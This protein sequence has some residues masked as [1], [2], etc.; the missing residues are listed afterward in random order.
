[1]RQ[2]TDTET[3][4][5]ENRVGD[6][7]VNV[8]VFAAGLSREFSASWDEG[9]GWRDVVSLRGWAGLS[10]VFGSTGLSCPW[11]CGRGQIERQQ[12]ANMYRAAMGMIPATLSGDG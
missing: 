12:H 1:M 2:R 9:N 6:E 7:C 8:C 11:E 3:S 10:C 4:D 5:W